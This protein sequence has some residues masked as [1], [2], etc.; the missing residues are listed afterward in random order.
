VNLLA[1]QNITLSVRGEAAEG[2][3]R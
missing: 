3:E 2:E 1:A